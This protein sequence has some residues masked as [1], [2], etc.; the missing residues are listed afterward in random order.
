[1]TEA[2]GGFRLENLTVQQ[3]ERF[4]E[5]REL[6]NSRK[7]WEAHEA[8]EDVWKELEDP[9]RRFL[10][11]LIQAAAA[12]HLIITTPRVGGALRNIEKSLDKLGPMPSVC[13]DLDVGE[14]TGA[15][16]NT[17]AEVHRLGQD[18]LSAFNVDL[19]PKL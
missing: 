10:Q 7:F 19:C 15:L 1:V 16:K 5:G 2:Q 8:W 11:G 18:G 12:Y 4:D 9:E 17:H 6:F 14:L 13:F 3:R